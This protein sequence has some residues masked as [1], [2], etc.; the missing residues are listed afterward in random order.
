MK[1]MPSSLLFLLA[2][3]LVLTATAC[4]T[5]QAGKA[6]ADPYEVVRGMTISCPQAGR[7]WGSDAMVETMRKLKSLGV[8]WVTIHPYAGIRKDGSVGGGL[9]SEPSSLRTVTEAAP[10]RAVSGTLKLVSKVPSE[11]ITG[12]LMMAMSLKKM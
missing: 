2:A 11:T 4:E 1:L 5:T 6:T 9:F 12:L 7:V 3:V 8:N 10:G